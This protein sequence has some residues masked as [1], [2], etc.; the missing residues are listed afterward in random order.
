MPTFAHPALLWGLLIAGLPVLIHLINMFRHRRV[1][2]AAMEFLLASQ[3]R[4]R[5]WVLLK[6]LLLLLMRV[7]A[8]AAVVLMLAQPYLPSRW[9]GVL[10]RRN[11]HHVVLLDDSYSMTDRWA[12][13]T[14][15]DEAKAT[16]ERIAEDASRQARRQSFSLLRFSQAGGEDGDARPDVLDEPIGGGF[17]EQLGGQL[18]KLAA[19]ETA[20]GPLGALEAVE[21]VFGREASEQ[22]IVYLLTDF[23]ARQWRNPAELVPALERI[24]RSGAALHLVGCVDRG[25]ANVSLA[26]LA[27]TAGTLAADVPFFMEVKVAN[28]SGAALND[29]LV[30]IEADGSPRPALR[31]PTIPPGETVAERFPLRFPT[32]GEHLVAAR[33]ESDAVALDNL[34]YAVVDLPADLPVLLIDG[35]LDSGDAVYL[36]AALQPGG[37]VATGITARIEKPRYLSQNPLGEFRAIYLLNVERL[38]DSAIEA[39]EEYASEGGGVAV[40]LGPACT[41]AFYN[42][43]LYRGGRG[44]FPLP[45]AGQEALPVDRLEKAPDIE[46]TDHPIFRIFSGDRNSFLSLVTIDRYFSVPENLPGEAHAS[47]AV[48]ARLRNGA[49]LALERQFGKGKV[50]VFLTTAGP[51]WNNWARG[52]PSYVVAMLELQAYL[53]GDAGALSS[54]LVGDALTVPL[55]PTRFQSQVRWIPPAASPSQA[56][57]SEAAAL[58]DGRFA[59]TFSAPVSGIYRAE[60]SGKDGSRQARRLAVN[61]DPGEGELDI[62]EPARLAEALEGVD[63]R[64]QSAATFQYAGEEL[65]GASLT[66]PLLLFLLALLLA[67]QIVAYWVGDHPRDPIGKGGVG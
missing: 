49:A 47:V 52:N 42:E 3:R 35:S 7:G 25:R 24:S 19:S 58:S 33:L 21:N 11:I 45:L 48:I 55:D 38:D 30:M 36:A 65:S 41:P 20:V 23:R 28:H 18:R 15:F 37:P 34:R 6:Q 44:L 61:V 10:D 43:R 40:F 50:V 17:L 9:G 29:V 26:G 51:A 53:A 27:P 62:V 2:W 56:A 63:F 31:I 1:R 8:V 66:E 39:L 59:A 67:E 12:D 60:L 16:V 54:H 5:T 13:T 4:N 64:Y 14:A 57:T 22:R 32:A 46:A